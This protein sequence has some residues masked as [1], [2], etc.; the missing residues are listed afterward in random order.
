[1][2]SSV[3]QNLI[4]VFCLMAGSFTIGSAQSSSSKLFGG[5][6]EILQDQYDKI[7]FGLG[8]MR[9]KDINRATTDD[10]I[11]AS[12]I[13]SNGFNAEIGFGVSSNFAIELAYQL[14]PT[15]I[16]RNTGQDGSKTTTH[17]KKMSTVGV[18][19][20]GQ[21]H[22]L[23]NKFKVKASAGFFV[24]LDYDGAGN[25]GGKSMFTNSEGQEVI[26]DTNIVELHSG[27]LPLAEVGLG[28]DYRISKKFSVGLDVR[29]LQ[30]FIDYNVAYIDYQID[31]M[32]GD[33]QVINNASAHIVSLNFKY[34]LK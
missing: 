12:S 4:L 19:F 3:L 33:A 32:T 17:L 13:W 11:S 24:G 9:Y 5:K 15:Q 20:V 2:K 26:I 7:Y 8:F 16:S 18:R 30:G 27:T 21:Q 22:F 14:N 29:R 31:Q 23:Q 1:M 25:P 34:K 28:I 6:K 10:F